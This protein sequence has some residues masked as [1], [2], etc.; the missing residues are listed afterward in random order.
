MSEIDK[1]DTEL[2]DLWSHRHDLDEAGWTRLYNIVERALKNYKPRELSGLREDND[3][4]IQEFFQD[5]VLRLDLLSRCDH[6]GALHLYYQ[7][8]LRDQIR[9]KQARAKWEVADEHD[10]EADSPPSLD[11]APEVKSDHQKIFSELEEAG[12]SPAEV[13]LSAAAWLES[14]E[15]WVRLF[16]ALSNCP[17]AEVSERLV[18]LAKRKGIK[19]QAY[20]AEKLGFN[21]KG[22]DPTG[23]A[24]TLLGRWITDLL[25]IEL[26][27]E[28]SNL[29]LAVL[30]ILCYQ[31]LLWA[32]QQEAAK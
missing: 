11:K 17:D 8:Y 4:Y 14:S 29:I 3:V 6:I 15:E 31:A 22:S 19:S 9:S 24:E 26:C 27:L 2:R 23:F 1:R 12:L 7:R 32:D 30:K 20:K 28:N 10:P 13:A 5:K 16:V 21:W 18:H 25:G